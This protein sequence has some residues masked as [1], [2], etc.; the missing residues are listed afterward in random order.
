MPRSK[1]IEILTGMARSGALDGDVVAL[2]GR[3][4]D[5][6]DGIRRAEQEAYAIGQA[7]LAR[8]MGQRPSAQNAV[9]VHLGG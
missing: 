8:C 4:F 9:A 1:S 3:D 7:W 2:V 6:I 5:D